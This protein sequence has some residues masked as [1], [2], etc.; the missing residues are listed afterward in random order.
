MP[1]RGTGVNQMAAQG[2]LTGLESGAF[3]SNPA[4]NLHSGLA[5]GTPRES[6]GR[7][8]SWGAHPVSTGS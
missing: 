1:V 3:P 4:G 6:T 5:F 7:A 2:G 8:G